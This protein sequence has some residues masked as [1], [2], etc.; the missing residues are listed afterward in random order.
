MKQQKAAPVRAVTVKPVAP[1]PAAATVDN[2]TPEQRYI[3]EVAPS[4]IVG[5][6]IKFGKDGRFIT[7][8]DGDAISEDTDFFALCGDVQIG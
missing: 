8:D 2:R 4:S 3:D 5:R 7:N 6:L 1:P